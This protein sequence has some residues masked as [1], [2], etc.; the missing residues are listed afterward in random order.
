MTTIES[1]KRDVMTILYRNEEHHEL[2]GVDGMESFDNLKAEE[3]VSKLIVPAMNRVY[4]F[5]PMGMLGGALSVSTSG[6]G[7]SGEGDDADLVDVRWDGEEDEYALVGHLSDS[8]LR[9]MT[10]KLDGWARPVSSF[11]TTDDDLYDQCRSPF[12]GIRPNIYYPTV[13]LGLDL[14]NGGSRIEAYPKSGVKEDGTVNA[15]LVYVKRFDASDVKTDDSGNSVLEVA[16]AC[17]DSLL[18]TIAELWYTSLGDKAR[19]DMMAAEA[20]QMLNIPIK[21]E[22]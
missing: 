16:G 13:V 7:T 9:V 10:V 14:M 2:V 1:I 6:A 12:E 5:A 18:Y 3:L 22:S 21:Q 11:I 20:A 15:R 19:A 8:I 4:M 17:Y